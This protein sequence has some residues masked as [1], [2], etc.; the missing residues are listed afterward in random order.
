MSDFTNI[1]DRSVVGNI[2]APYIDAGAAALVVLMLEEFKGDPDGCMLLDR[3]QNICDTN[4]IDR[5][6]ATD[7]LQNE[8]FADERYNS[9][10]R[11]SEFGF[12]VAAR[13]LIREI[14]SRDD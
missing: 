8:G 1:I 12:S 6:D 9:E 14:Q 10:I 7:H 11:A 2:I 13:L 3:F 5:E 4:G